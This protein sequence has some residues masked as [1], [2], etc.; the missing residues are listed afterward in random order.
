MVATQSVEPIDLLIVD[1]E[2]DFLEPACRFFQ[3]QGYRV[4]A[5]ANAEQALA[6]QAKQHFHLAVIDQ[7]M[8]GMNGLD[9]LVRL[10]EEDEDI[11]VIMLTGGG[12]ILSAVEAM[13]RGAIDYLP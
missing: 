8:P 2:P 12:N 10:R 4:V 6:V 5:A 9:L 11:K 1:D 13:K 3:R 7:N